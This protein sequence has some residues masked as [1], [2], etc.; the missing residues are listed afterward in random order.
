MTEKISQVCTHGL[1]SNIEFGGAGVSWVSLV[2]GHR[3]S[4]IN[5]D[6]IARAGFAGLAKNFASTVARLSHEVSGLG[7]RRPTPGPELQIADF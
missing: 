4:I 1:A 6:V 3:D 2:F 5:M 7:R